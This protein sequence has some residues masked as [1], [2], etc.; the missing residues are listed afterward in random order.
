M[1]SAL[2]EGGIMRETML[3]ASETAP[4]EVLN[5][6]ENLSKEYLARC[7]KILNKWGAPLT[8]WHCINVV[9]VREEDDEAELWI[10]ELCGCKKVRFIHV[11]D[12]ALYFEPVRVGCICAGVM[13]G[14]VLAAKERER[15]MRN[16][17]K[18]RRTFVK[19][20][21]EHPRSGLWYRVYHGQELMITEYSGAYYVQAGQGQRARTT[22]KYKGKPIRDLYS[23]FY[24]AFDLVDPKDSFK[25]VFK[26]V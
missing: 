2:N 8:G 1:R 20:K 5:G 25:E 4:S 9:D 7:L 14:D 26:E 19:H 10:C 15:R 11:M 21:W 13:E 22:S 24:A 3:K 16:R 23:A 17:A 12:N 18:R 6:S